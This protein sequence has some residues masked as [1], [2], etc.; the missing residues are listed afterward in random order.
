M[1]SSSGFSFPIPVKSLGIAVTA[2]A[3]ASQ[4]LPNVGNTAAFLNEGPNICFVA[5]AAAASSAVATLPA[6]SAGTATLTSNPIPLGYS[7]L[8]IPN[9]QVYNISL[10]CRSTQTAQVTVQVGEGS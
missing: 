3:S 7:T 9:D 2:T 5:I 4:A 1:P 8:T 10:I 6:T